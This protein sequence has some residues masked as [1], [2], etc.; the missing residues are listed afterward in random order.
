MYVLRFFNVPPGNKNAV[1][2]NPPR[3]RRNPSCLQLTM[4]ACQDQLNAEF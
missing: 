4:S 3:E 2:P 1:V